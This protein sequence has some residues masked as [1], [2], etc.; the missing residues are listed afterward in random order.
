LVT[1]IDELKRMW[2]ETVGGHYKVPLYTN[3][4]LDKLRKETKILS[5][6]SQSLDE[7]F[8]HGICPVM[9]MMID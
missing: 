2:K 6:D 9:M 8:K 3:I 4:C 1:K 5:K 7:N